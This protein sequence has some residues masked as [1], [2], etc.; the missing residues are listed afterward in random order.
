MVLIMHV[1]S[2]L[3]VHVV[4]KEVASSHVPTIQPV[5][6]IYLMMN[7]TFL[8]LMNG[9]VEH[10]QYIRAILNTSSTVI[11]AKNFCI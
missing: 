11:Y 6:Q 3:K 10:K 2:N 8:I 9:G 1:S 5:T 7:T 4:C